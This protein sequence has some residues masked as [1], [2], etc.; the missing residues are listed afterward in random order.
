MLPLKPTKIDSK[1]IKKV[2]PKGQGRGK[3]LEQVRDAK[4]ILEDGK[5][6]CEWEWSCRERKLRSHT[7]LSLLFSGKGTNEF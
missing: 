2:N 4:Y 1:G 7:V 5:Q 3:G 6:K